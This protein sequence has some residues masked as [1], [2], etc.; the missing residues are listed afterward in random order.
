MPHALFEVEYSTY[1][2][3]SLL[4]FMDLAAFNARMVIVADKKRKEEFL[5][6]L[7][8]NA[9]HRLNES[10]RVEFLSYDTLVAIY[11]KES[12][13]AALNFHI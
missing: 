13:L 9:F 4:K 8:F 11:E 12:E 3:D 10:N 6:K 5:S 2:Q 7:K 1:I